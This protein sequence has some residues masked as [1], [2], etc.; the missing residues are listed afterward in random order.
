LKDLGEVLKLCAL[1]DWDSEVRLTLKEAA[2]LRALEVFS[3]AHMEAAGGL[4]DVGATGG[5][6]REGAMVAA[7]E[8]LVE[9]LREVLQ[10]V[11]PFFAPEHRASATFVGQYDAHI[12]RQVAALHE[13]GLSDLELG[14]LFE[15]NRFLQDFQEQVR[16]HA[17]GVS[18]WSEACAL[19]A[20][21]SVSLSLSACHTTKAPS[22]QPTAHG[23]RSWP[24][25]RRIPAPSWP[26]PPRPVCR[27]AWSRR[28][29]R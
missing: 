16:A 5:L 24:W 21:L 25:A 9:D 7:A 12:S 19:P 27:S 18:R 22:N 10:R 8:A 6:S 3:V 29:S 17:H 1:E 15:V 4:S 14:D 28:G 20:S 11:A 13:H 26:P 23:T 2:A